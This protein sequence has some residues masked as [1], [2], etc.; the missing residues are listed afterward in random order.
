MSLIQILIVAVDDFLDLS[1]FSDQV[2]EFFL[3]KL[4][5]HFFAHWAAADKQTVHSV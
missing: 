4:F 1:H 5:L 3:L 2:N